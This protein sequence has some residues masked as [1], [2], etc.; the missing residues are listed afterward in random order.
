MKSG[1]DLATFRQAFTDEDGT[2]PDCEIVGSGVGTSRDR[3]ST[4]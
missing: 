4:R 1:V 3:Q 2:L